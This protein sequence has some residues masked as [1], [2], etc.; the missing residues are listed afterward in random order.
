MN[1][2]ESEGHMPM[3]P[4]QGARYND[5][6]R[7]FIEG[8]MSD[9]EFAKAIARA[10]VYGV[11]DTVFNDMCRKLAPRLGVTPDYISSSVSIGFMMRW[12]PFHGTGED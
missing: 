10:Q 6:A 5:G 12:L 9:P 8:N 7:G 3:T 2:L 11:A 4:E 1:L